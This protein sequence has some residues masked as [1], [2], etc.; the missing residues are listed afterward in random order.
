MSGARTISI[1]GSTGSVG[2][3]ALSVVEHA[4]AQSTDPVFEVDTLAAGRNA[5]LLIEQARQLRLV[6][7]NVRLLHGGDA[8][9]V[10]PSPYDHRPDHQRNGG[11]Q[12]IHAHKDDAFSH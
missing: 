8:S 6:R 7:L 2:T 9:D 3:S 12:D 10:H 4:N 11:L 5:D 1:L